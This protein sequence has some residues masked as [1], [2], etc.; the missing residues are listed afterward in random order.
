MLSS[1]VAESPEEVEKCN[2]IWPQGYMN[3]LIDLELMGPNTLFYHSVALSDE[4]I[5]MYAKTGTKAA[6][7]P[8]TNAHVGNCARVPEMLRAGVTVGLGTDSP[9]C[10]MFNVMRLVGVIH[11]IKPR[12]KEYLTAEQVFEMATIGGAK[13]NQLEDQIGTLEVGKKADIITLDL[14]NNT[15]LFPLTKEILIQFL[16]ENGSGT[17]VDNVIID[18]NILMENR[19]PKHL[20]EEAILRNAQKVTDDLVEWYVDARK[21]G[22]DMIQWI[23]PEYTADI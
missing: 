23:H 3:H 1:H 20:D 16:V 5:T 21:K 19:K 18:G 14:S 22:K 7:C 17:D 11:N 8:I 9:H 10:D 2:K 12:P 4:D 6:H 13:A 15:R